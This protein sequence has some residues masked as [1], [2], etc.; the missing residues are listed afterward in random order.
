MP[1][2][3]P[4]AGADDLLGGAHADRTQTAGGLD[5][6]V[7]RLVL[8]CCHPAIAPASQSALCLRLLCGLTTEEI[9]RAFLVSEET[10]TRRLS[11]A[12]LKIRTAHIPFRLP[13]TAELEGRLAGAAGTLYLMFNEG[14]AAT[15]GAQA[16][17]RPLIDESLRLA[18]LLH[19]LLPQ[20]AT[21]CGLLALML[22]QQSREAARVDVL[23]EPVLLADQD[24]SLWDR[25]SVVEGTTLLGQG[26]ALSPDAPNAY[27]VQAA[28]AACH[29]LAPSW[30]STDWQAICSWYDVLMGIQP[31]PVVALNRAVAIG[32]RDGPERALAEVEQLT[33][34]SDY[35]LWHA[36][37][38]E[39]LGRM[40]RDADAA[41]ALG[42]ALALQLSE[43]LRRQL[44]RRLER[45]SGAGDR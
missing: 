10:M 21:T 9:A 26:L 1:E 40:G 8:L 43:P 16:M 6:D 11:R 28:I 33:T 15:G 29:A 13:P 34:L 23:G 41:R 45:L 2:A 19:Q 42:D 39:L 18:R 25:A 5:D 38:A 4:G 3:E 14:Y 22:L 7:L 37:R 27:V 30:S 20:S 17:R 36:T 35:P 44:E 24:R 12:K 31:T 32:E